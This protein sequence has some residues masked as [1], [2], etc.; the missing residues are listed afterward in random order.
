MN[1]KGGGIYFNNYFEGD[2]FYQD[3]GGDFIQI[4]PTNIFLNKKGQ[5][6]NEHLHLVKS[7]IMFVHM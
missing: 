5:Q 6:L 2:M 1:T 3:G 7:V 4:S